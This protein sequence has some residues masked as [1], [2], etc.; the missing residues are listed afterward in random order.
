M[1]IMLWKIIILIKQVYSCFWKK[2]KHI[3]IL[4]Q[5]TAH[6]LIPVRPRNE[7]GLVTK[8][9]ARIFKQ[10]RPGLPNLT[11]AWVECSPKCCSPSIA[12]ERSPK[13]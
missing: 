5:K 13:P 8:P 9:V 7:C 3:K 11:P 6:K 1:L 12:S 4:S 2:R 10:Q